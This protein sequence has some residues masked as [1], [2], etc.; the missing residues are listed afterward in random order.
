MDLLSKF[1]MVEV[2]SNHRITEED[3]KFC[4]SNQAAY[5]A[6]KNSLA[7]LQFFW[8]DMLDN[9]RKLLEGTDTSGTLYLTGSDYLDISSEKIK[10]QIKA[11]H[12]T[13]IEKLVDYFNRLYHVTISYSKIEDNLI[14]QKP[15]YCPSSLRDEKLEQYKEEQRQYENKLL[16]LSLNYESI[17]DQIFAQMDGRGLLEQA[18][19]ELKEKCHSAAWGYYSKEPEYEQH[20]DVLRFTRYACSYDGSYGSSS[21]KLCDGM[22]NILRGI[23]HFETDTFSY[24]PPVISN[25]L[26]YSV[27]Y[28]LAEF[29]YCQKVKQLK[30][31]K[32]GRVD[33]K[34]ADADLATQFATEYLGTVY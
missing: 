12:K 20:K 34:F 3:K 11:L 19:H 28:D 18:L 27:K 17:L 16:N 25:L 7:E 10:K 5:E 31:F 6:A 33:I 14:P 1:E 26:G 2:T 13:F 24:I 15:D 29:Y 8:E 32:N 21:W 4:E 30:M 9:Q 23:A 22:K